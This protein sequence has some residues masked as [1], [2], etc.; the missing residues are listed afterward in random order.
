MVKN[1]GGEQGIMLRACGVLRV[2][3]S[4]RLLNMFTR[5]KLG[6]TSEEVVRHE[7]GDVPADIVPP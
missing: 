6:T 3:P 1:E 2:A 5:S 4:L 7:E